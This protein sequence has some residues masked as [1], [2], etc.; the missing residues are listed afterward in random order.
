V[1]EVAGGRRGRAR[2]L[3]LG[4]AAESLG[5]DAS[6]LRAWADAGDVRF[7]RTPGGH[8]RFDREDLDRL[9]RSTDSRPVKPSP[10][11]AVAAPG[12]AREWLA[13]R[14][15]FTAIPDSSRARVRGYCAELMQ[16]VGAYLDGRRARPRHRAAAR[17]AGVSL[18][19]EV[20]GWGLTPGQSAEV[21]VYFKRHVTEALASMHA[22]EAA[23]VQC[24]R[25]ADA[26]LGDVLQAVMEAYGSS[27]DDARGAPAKSAQ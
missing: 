23:R 5:V 24:L 6:T 19:R 7:F 20:A 9:A 3:T 2:W 27:P 11:R 16:V 10:R 15:W 22:E 21:F 18:G 26:F 12:S 1:N 13:A 14:P 8:R 25:D 4:E 17:R